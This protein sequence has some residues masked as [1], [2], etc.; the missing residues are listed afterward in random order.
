MPPNLISGLYHSGICEGES[1][2]D[3]GLAKGISYYYPCIDL[4]PGDLAGGSCFYLLLKLKRPLPIMP[5]CPWVAI[6][7]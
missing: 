5:V 7:P 6:L 3:K 2:V 4:A 1:N